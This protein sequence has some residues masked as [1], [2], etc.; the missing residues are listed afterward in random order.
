MAEQWRSRERWK[1]K[2]LVRTLRIVGCLNGVQWQ[3][4][5]NERVAL[6]SFP[7]GDAGYNAAR[8]TDHAMILGTLMIGARRSV[9]ACTGSQVGCVP[10][11]ARQVT[12]CSPCMLSI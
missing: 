2:S 8:T 11:H 5:A 1:L 9:Q 10:P 7:E 12:S 4:I 6:R 3:E